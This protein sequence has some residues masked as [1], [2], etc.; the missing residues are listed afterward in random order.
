MKRSSTKKIK[1]TLLGHLLNI[2]EA[3]AA[4]DFFALLNKK[5]IKIS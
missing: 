2:A 3:Q 4:Y 5:I 1:V